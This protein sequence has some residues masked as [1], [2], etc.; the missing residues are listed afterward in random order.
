VNVFE[1]LARQSLIPELVPRPLVP[2]AVT[3]SSV[4]VNVARIFGAALGGTIASV[5]GLALCFGLNAVG[6]AA[7]LLT[8][9]LKSTDQMPPGPPGPLGLP[10]PLGPLGPLGLPGPLGPRESLGPTGPCSAPGPWSLA[11][12]ACRERR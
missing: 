3:L 5:L 10:G 2:N 12:P 9:A 1:N 11:C 4:T 8:L 7:V 6:F